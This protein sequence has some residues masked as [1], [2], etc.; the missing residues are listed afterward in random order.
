M[1]GTT[2]VATLQEGAISVN[3]NVLGIAIDIR[4][5]EIDVDDVTGN[6]SLRNGDYIMFSKNKEANLSGLIGYFMEV[7]FTCNSKERAEIHSMGSDTVIN[8]Q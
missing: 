2:P 4:E 1:Q 5:L 6:Y 8:S 3:N 7:T